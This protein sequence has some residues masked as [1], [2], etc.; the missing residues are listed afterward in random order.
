MDYVRAHPRKRW[1]PLEKVEWIA[2][3]GPASFAPG[4]RYEYNDSGYVSSRW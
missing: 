3:E 1:T 4:E 2:D